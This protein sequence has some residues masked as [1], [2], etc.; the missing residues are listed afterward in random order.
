MVKEIVLILLLFLLL[1]FSYVKYIEFKGVYYPS[2]GIEHFP[3]AAGLSFEDV[4]ISTEDGVQINGWFISIPEAKYTI[5]LFHGNAGNIGNRIDKIN[6][7][8]RIGLNVFIIDYRGFG[9]S[10]GRANEAGLYLDAQAAYGYLLNTRKI[11]PELIIAYGESLG[12]AVAIDLASKRELKALI[13]E[14]GFSRGRDMAGKI[15][16]FLPKFIFSNS[17]DSI[18]KI[19]KIE[20]AKL[21]IHTPSDEVVPFALARRLYDS[22]ASPKEFVEI[23]GSHGMAFLDSQE[24]Y[25]SSI[26]EFVK[27]L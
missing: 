2:G 16:R 23:S 8:S 17:F 6:L 5:L 27:K 24:K 4:Y 18:N 22:A 20:A 9:R 26:S 1:L 7:L 3:S 21:F 10:Q 12:T 13:I 25:V 11:K 15:Y 14:G 19:R